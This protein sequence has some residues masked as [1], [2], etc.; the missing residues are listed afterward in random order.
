MPKKTTT[1]KSVPAKPKRVTTAAKKRK[2]AY[3][4][5]EVA[6]HAYFIAEKRQRL[7]LPGD[8][9]SDWIEAEQQLRFET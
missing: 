4:Q 1:T 7:G 3:S 9:H 6:L 8:A 5:E 2:P